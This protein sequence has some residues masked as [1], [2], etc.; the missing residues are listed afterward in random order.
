MNLFTIP[1]FCSLCS[2]LVHYLWN[3]L[4]AYWVWVKTNYLWTQSCSNTECLTDSCELLELSNPT[5]IVASWVCFYS[6]TLHTWPRP[7]WPQ[8]GCPPCLPGLTTATVPCQCYT[9]AVQ[10]DQW[11]LSISNCPNKDWLEFWSLIGWVLFSIFSYHT[12]IFFIS[13]IFVKFL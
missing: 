7:A 8:P 11:A 6:W 13:L 3:S 9:Y 12:C 10:G 1:S 2:V 4:I 5:D